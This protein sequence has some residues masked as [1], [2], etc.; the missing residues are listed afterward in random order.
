MLGVPAKAISRVKELQPYHRGKAFKSDPLWRLNFLW[1]T[2]KHRSMALHSLESDVIFHVER[3]VP[4]EERK[5][6]DTTVVTVADAC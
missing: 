4:I 5:F 3:G 2:D 1:N 6:D